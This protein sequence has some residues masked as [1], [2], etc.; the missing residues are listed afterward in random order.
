MKKAISVLAIMGLSACMGG[1]GGSDVS[2]TSAEPDP[3]VTAEIGSLLN[4]AR[5]TMLPGLEYQADVGRVAQTHAQ[6]MVDEPFLNI[7][8]PGSTGCAGPRGGECDMGDALNGISRNWDEIVQMVAQGD[9]SVTVL[10]TEFQGR[11]SVDNVGEGD[12]WDKLDG[13]LEF[14]GDY[15][16]FGLGKAGSGSDTKWALL[17]V[18]PFEFWSER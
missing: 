6:A 1:G 15:E 3:T 18:D 2:V 8:V 9:Q 16:F 7:F 13:A 4:G 12:T 14:D 5:S 17:V 11:T 10:W